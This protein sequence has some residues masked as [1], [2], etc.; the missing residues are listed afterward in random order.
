MQE[1]LVLTRIDYILQ[2]G[3]VNRGSNVIAAGM[4]V[5]DWIAFCGMDTTSMEMSVIENVFKLNETN[6][7][8]IT[9]NMRASLIER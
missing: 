3:T 2:A 7:A 9:S 5:N 1:S 8:A 6:P 4:V